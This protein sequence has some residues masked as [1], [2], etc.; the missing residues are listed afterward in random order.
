MTP[1]LFRRLRGCARLLY[2]LAT[3]KEVWEVWPGAKCLGVKDG[4]R[5][6]RTED[7]I[8]ISYFKAVWQALR[9]NVI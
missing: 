9:G 6:Y 1:P 3:G 7:L 4:R 2:G 8:P 5:C